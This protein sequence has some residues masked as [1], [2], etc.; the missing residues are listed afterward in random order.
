MNSEGKPG[1]PLRLALTILDTKSCSPISGALVDLWHC[2][3]SGAYS[4][5]VASG[6]GGMNRQTDNT[7]FFRGKREFP[8]FF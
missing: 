6:M 1:I 3:T 8:S 2:D 7:T 5:F 4:H